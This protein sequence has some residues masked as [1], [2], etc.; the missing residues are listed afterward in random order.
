M[1]ALFF[2]SVAL[3]TSI[4]GVLAQLYTVVNQATYFAVLGG[5]AVVLGAALWFGRKPVLRLMAGVR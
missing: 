4:A 5:I 3:G 2:L 1:V